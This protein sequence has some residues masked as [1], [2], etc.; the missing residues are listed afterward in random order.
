MLVL[1]SRCWYEE[2]IYA[3]A[4]S[5]LISNSSSV[6]FDSSVVTI[7]SLF[8]PEDLTSKVLRRFLSVLQLSSVIAVAISGL[9]SVVVDSGTVTIGRLVVFRAGVVSVGFIGR[10]TE[11]G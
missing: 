9:D 6:I 8:M 3:A 10:V 2:S 4:S 7:D 11:S 1:G 5:E